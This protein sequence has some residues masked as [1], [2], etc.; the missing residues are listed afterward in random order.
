MS[1]SLLSDDRSVSTELCILQIQLEL[2]DKRYVDLSLSHEKNK[3]LTERLRQNQ[4][5]KIVID[6]QVSE[7]DGY[8]WLK[9]GQNQESQN[10]DGHTFLYICGAIGGAIIIGGGLL[11]LA[12]FCSL[13][14]WELVLGAIF[15]AVG[16][17][18]LGICAIDSWLE[19]EQNL[20]EEI[21][22][23]IAQQELEVDKINNEINLLEK[24]KLI[25]DDHFKS[26][27]CYNLS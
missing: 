6:H 2:F 19:K 21:K 8:F 14:F 26:E 12:C 16:G 10:I 4:S 5:V 1:F 13:A 7:D 25:G 20:Q 27:G 15:F 9:E 3:K 18:G 17:A 11:L 24:N 23:L 22:K